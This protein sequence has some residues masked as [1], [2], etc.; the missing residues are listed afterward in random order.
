MVN[1]VCAAYKAAITP[2]TLRHTTFP[3]YTFSRVSPPS[4]MLHINVGIAVQTHLPWPE[5][6][7]DL[8]KEFPHIAPNIIQIQYVKMLE[9]NYQTVRN[10][11][12]R[13]IFIK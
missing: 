4:D 2:S 8:T 13:H 3:S 10:D 1:P 12:I 11:V 7:S 5:I 9:F 6:L